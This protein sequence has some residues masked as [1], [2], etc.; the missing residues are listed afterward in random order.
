VT[1]AVD[2]LEV[3]VHRY[4]R[5]S[6]LLTSN[7]RWTIGT[8]CSVIPLPSPRCSRGLEA[9]LFI[10][11][12]NSGRGREPKATRGSASLTLPRVVSRILIA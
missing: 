3:I 2:L 6:T 11:V 9:G 1:A 8:S 5:A 4:E 7:H 12:R 10:T